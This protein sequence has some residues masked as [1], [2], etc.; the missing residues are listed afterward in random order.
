MPSFRV[1]AP[2]LLGLLAVA[3]PVLADDRAPAAAPPDAALADAGEPITS[4]TL[5]APAPAPRWTT[6]GVAERG[7]YRWSLSRGALDLGL[8]FEPR[9]APARPIDGRYDSAAPPGVTFPALSFGL[10]SVVAEPGPADSL[11]ERVLGTSTSVKEVSKIGIEWKPAQSQVF[12]NQGV[13]VRLN[14]D[15]RLIMRLRKGSLGLYM[16]RNF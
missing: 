15:D 3:A 8:R 16:Q 4:S 13:G 14:D 9:L 6:N 11:A 2:L 12:F 10:R 5:P 7:G 1:I